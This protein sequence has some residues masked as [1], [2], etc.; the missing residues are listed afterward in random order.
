MKIAINTCYGGFSLSPEATLELWKRGGPVEATPIDEYFG[1]DKGKSPG[2]P[3]GKNESLAR[4]REYLASDR[5]RSSFVTVFSPDESLALYAGRL[6]GDAMRADPILVK[7]IE[8]MGDAAN[9]DCAEIKI[10]DVPDGVD[11][12]I[13][14]YDG[15]EHVAEKHRSWS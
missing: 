10:V 4:W 14:E 11:W 6:S 15:L 2:E 5:K 13:S 1:V 3:C 7:L 12:E 8:E 9:G